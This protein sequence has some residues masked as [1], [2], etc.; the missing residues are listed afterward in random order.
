M[1]IGGI[2][3]ICADRCVAERGAYSGDSSSWEVNAKPESWLRA[4]ADAVCW[5]IRRGALRGWLPF[6]IVFTSH[7]LSK[8]SLETAF[9][10]DLLCRWPDR[11]PD[12]ES[13][14]QSLDRRSRAPGGIDSNQ[15]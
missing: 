2:R 9:C 3:D 7:K 5:S 12:A 13:E 6:A 15:G 8:R 4:G 1:Y 14:Q 10:L 11:S